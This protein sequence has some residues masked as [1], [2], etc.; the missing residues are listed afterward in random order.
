[1][2]KLR[3]EEA[4]A[5][6]QARIDRGE[7]TIVGVNKYRLDDQDD[8]DVREIDNADVRE[9]QIARLTGVEGKVT[10]KP[11]TLNCMPNS[12]CCSQTP[13]SSKCCPTWQCASAPRTTCSASSASLS[14][15]TANKPSSL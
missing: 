11:S 4:A 8:V 9:Q 6:R 3:I 15:R 7:E 1:M 14:L 12:A 2:P 5:R 13:T 10:L